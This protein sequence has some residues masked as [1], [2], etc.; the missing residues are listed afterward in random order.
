M[1]RMRHSF[2][3]SSMLGWKCREGRRKPRLAFLL[4]ECSLHALRREANLTLSL[5]YVCFYK[6]LFASWQNVNQSMCTSAEKRTQE[7]LNRWREHR[8]KRKEW[9]QCRRGRRYAGEVKSKHTHFLHC[10]WD[11]FIFCTRAEMYSEYLERNTVVCFYKNNLL[12]SN[13]AAHAPLDSTF[14]HP[15]NESK[16]SITLLKVLQR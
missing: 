6:E 2:I 8:Q 14:L 7:R 15:D 11:V 3:H 5:P 10:D 12:S 9:Q 4:S 13:A 16:S 1:W